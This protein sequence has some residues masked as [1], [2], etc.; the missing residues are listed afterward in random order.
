MST[1]PMAGMEEHPDIAALRARYDRVAETTSAHTLDGLTFL[2]GL[3]LAISPWVVGFHARTTSLTINDLITGIA[4]SLLA[5][6]FASA[7]GRTHGLAWLVPLLGIWT[8][9]APWVVRGA[10]P[11]TGNI[12][13]NVLTGA[14]IT[15]FGLGAVGIGMMTKKQR[16]EMQAGMPGRPTP[17]RG[18]I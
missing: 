7:Y 4:I 2:S 8:I 14:L 3:Y 17:R 5:L 18:M 9:I 13:S 12:V 1:R 15:L 16:G 11:S 10:R 6:A